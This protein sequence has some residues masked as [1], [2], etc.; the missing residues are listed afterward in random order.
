M[1]MAHLKEQL[2][3]QVKLLANFLLKREKNEQKK[4]KTITAK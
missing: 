1:V 3:F 2:F 4:K